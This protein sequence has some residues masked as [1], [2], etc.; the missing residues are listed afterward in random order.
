MFLVLHYYRL[1]K[2]KSFRVYG[3][4][5]LFYKLFQMNYI[6]IHEESRKRINFINSY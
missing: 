4:I 1:I 6:C 3:A 2:I 5:F